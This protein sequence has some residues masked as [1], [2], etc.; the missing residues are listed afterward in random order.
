MKRTREQLAIGDMSRSIELQPMIIPGIYDGLWSAYYVVII[1]DNGNK[2]EKIKLNQGVRGIN[3]DCV[4]IVD[5]NGQV[6]V[7]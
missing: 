1:F 7:E 4:V 6:Y 2:S 5:E 3:I